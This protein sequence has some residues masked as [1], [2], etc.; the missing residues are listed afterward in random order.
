MI[1][2]F[3]LMISIILV[4]IASYMKTILYI[5]NEILTSDLSNKELIGAILT[6][7]R[8]K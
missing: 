4:T 8:V 5:M 3:F 2:F 7:L 6:P 1:S